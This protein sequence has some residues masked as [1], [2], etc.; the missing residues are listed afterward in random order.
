MVKSIV[1]GYMENPQS[2]I[3][4]VILAN[5]DIATQEILTI[6]EEVVND[7]NRTLGI[8]MKP[9]LVDSSTETP[10]LE[11]IRGKRHKLNLG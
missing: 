6:V 7:G 9:D 4:T 1:R 5:V 11:L 10:I 8:L 3:L 2:V